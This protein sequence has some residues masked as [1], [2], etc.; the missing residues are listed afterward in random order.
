MY[1]PASITQPSETNAL[2][3]ISVMSVFD[4]FTHGQGEQF[5][6]VARPVRDLRLRRYR[7]G[8]IAR[9]VHAGDFI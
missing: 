3:T 1:F 6:F 5:H 9:A 7:H 2:S 4:A 8:T